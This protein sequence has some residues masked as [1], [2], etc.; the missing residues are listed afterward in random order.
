MSP[1]PDSENRAFHLKSAGFKID[2]GPSE[3][4][5]LPKPQTAGY[6]QGHE[7]K[8]DR[9]KARRFQARAR[10]RFLLILRPC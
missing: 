6:K 9:S 3:A 2:V 1:S 7:F 5:G 4:Q 8:C 10:V